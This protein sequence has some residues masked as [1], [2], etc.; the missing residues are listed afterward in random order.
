MCFCHQVS[1]FKVWLAMIFSRFDKD[2]EQFFPTGV[3]PLSYVLNTC[4]SHSNCWAER[5]RA[6]VAWQKGF[7][8]R[9]LRFLDVYGTW[10]LNNLKDLERLT[11]WSVWRF[12][13]VFTQAW[14]AIALPEPSTVVVLQS[15]VWGLSGRAEP[16]GVNWSDIDGSFLIR[17]SQSKNS[18]ISCQWFS[19][20]L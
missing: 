13:M 8:G 14:L 19:S 3:S 15:E 9:F 16:S 17:L 7:H 4:D 18:T 2:S 11:V 5:F 1:V 12:E 20:C 10:H 6:N